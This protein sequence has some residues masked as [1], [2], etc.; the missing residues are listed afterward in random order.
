MKVSIQFVLTLFVFILC[1]PELQ[2]QYQN[3]RRYGNGYGNGYG[4][5]SSTLPRVQSPPQEAKPLTA[6][7]VLDQQMPKI[8]ETL[9]LNDFEQAVVSTTLLKYFKERQQLQLLSLEPE[10]AREGYEAILKKENDEL[11][12]GLP[13][14]KYQ[15]YLDLKE[16]GFNKAN[17]KKK[18]K[19]KKK[20][21]KS[22]EDEK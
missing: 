15:A 19:K 11:K 16:E 1:A 12:A 20:K 9:E 3:G 22:K 14:E 4:R 21:D 17:R 13:E 18:K 8:T 2:A 7:E 5:R 6:E 10:K